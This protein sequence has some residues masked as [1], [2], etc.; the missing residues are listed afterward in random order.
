MQQDLTRANSL[1][2]HSEEFTTHA[3]FEQLEISPG[4]FRGRGV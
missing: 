3:P 1:M 2:R 4:H